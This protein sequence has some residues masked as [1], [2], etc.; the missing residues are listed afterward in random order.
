MHGR[1][2]IFKEYDESTDCLIV[3]LEG[4]SEPWSVGSE[5]FFPELTNQDE[6]AAAVAQAAKTAIINTVHIEVDEP[7]SSKTL[8][9]TA[10][11]GYF[12]DDKFLDN[13]P[14]P[15]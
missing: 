7:R 3:Q 6:R 14:Q 15:N 4:E 8:V 5:V 11:R 9:G 12:V 13:P 10:S 1:R 2:G